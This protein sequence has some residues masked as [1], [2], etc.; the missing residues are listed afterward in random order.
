MTA[1]TDDLENS[2]RLLSLIHSL[3]SALPIGGSSHAFGLETYIEMCIITNI[4]QLEAF[5]QN[6][7]HSTLVRFDGYALK[8]MYL[9]IYDE[10]LWKLSLLDKIVHV[11][12]SPRESRESAR[13]LGHRMLHIYKIYYP[14][15]PYDELESS[16]QEYR[17]YGTLLTIF[18]WTMYHLKIRCDDAVQGYLYTAVATWVN[19]GLQHM[20]LDLTEAPN[21]INRLMPEISHQWQ[22][23][24]EGMPERLASYGMEQEMA[25]VPSESLYSKLFTI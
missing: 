19:C 22:V 5:L 3:D 7:L 16:I 14:N 24:S 18:A 6:Q 4:P 21:I 13:Q 12:R 1:S 2:L 23:A 17:S 11:Q 20:T 8:S 15:I 9:A 25:T 10:D